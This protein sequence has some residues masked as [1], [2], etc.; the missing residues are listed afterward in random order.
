MNSV[1]LK[2]HGISENWSSTCHNWV[3][4]WQRTKNNTTNREYSARGICWSFPRSSTMLRLETP[5]GGSH[6][7]HPL[8]RRRWQNTVYG[9]V[10]IRAPLGSGKSHILLGGG[11]IAPNLWSPRLLDRFRHSI[12]LYVNFS[13][14]TFRVFW[15][16][17]HCWRH[18]SGQSRNVR[19]FGLGDTSVSK[20][21]MLSAN[22]AN[23]WTIG[24]E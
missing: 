9:R 23:E 22:K 15:P 2:N 6:H 11:R 17:G 1:K 19:Y 4:Y 10:L 21:S 5:G 3:K 7:H 14:H 16:R 13:T 24:H 8:H 20:I 18:R 12:A